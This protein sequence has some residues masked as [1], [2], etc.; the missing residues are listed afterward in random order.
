[1]I[2]I[3]DVYN[4]DKETA[5]SFDKSFDENHSYRTKSVLAVPM[6]DK[7]EV[8]GVLE[9]MNMHKEGQIVSFDGR[10]EQFASH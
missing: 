2:N 3:E 6:M 9:L 10:N 4:M 5:F 8:I 7:D 1:M